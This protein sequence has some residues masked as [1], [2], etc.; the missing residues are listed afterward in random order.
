MPARVLLALILLVHPCRGAAMAVLGTL[1]GVPAACSPVA[2]V[3]CCPLCDM[4]DGCPCV[5]GEDTPAPVPLTALPPE[6]KES[7]RPA[8]HARGVVRPACRA[9]SGSPR[10]PPAGSLRS[11]DPTVSRFLSRLCVW[12]T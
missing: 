7:P 10:A 6:I 2:G 9:A 11:L 12:A 3:V 1:G 4:L 8:A 5:L